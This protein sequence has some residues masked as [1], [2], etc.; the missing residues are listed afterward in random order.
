LDS[1]NAHTFC[2]RD[3]LEEELELN[4]AYNYMLESF[5]ALYGKTVT[6]QWHFGNGPVRLATSFHLSCEGL[7]QGEATATVYF[8]VLA[9]RLYRK[10]LRILDGR[11]VLFVLADDDKILGPPEVIKE[12]AE[13]FPTLAWEE[14]SLTTQTFKNRIFVQSSAQARWSRLLAMTTR[15]MM[16]ELRVHGIPDGS[17]L[18]DPF[19]SDSERIWVEESRVNI[20]GTPLGSNTYVASYLRGKGPKHHLLLQFIKDVA[21]AGFPREAEQM[22]KGAAIPRLSHI[23]RSVQRNNHT[24]GWM[25]EMDGAH[26]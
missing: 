2:S 12:M 15:N 19:N 14:A 21:A 4:V 7:R 3:R 16:T 1:K 9:A 17:E 6:V 13:G 11:G 10:Q 23:M 22:L 24:V 26:L 18:V 8:N 25:T 20:M 5:K